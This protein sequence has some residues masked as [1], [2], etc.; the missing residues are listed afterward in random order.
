M[1]S[2]ITGICK[3][4]GGVIF[5]A[6]VWELSALTLAVWWPGALEFS[7]TNNALVCCVSDTAITYPIVSDIGGTE[8]LVPSAMPVHLIFRPGE[9]L[10]HREI[11]FVMT[12]S[13]VRSPMSGINSDG[14]ISLRPDLSEALSLWEN[15]VINSVWSDWTRA[16]LRS[17]LSYVK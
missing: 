16:L 8:Y 5:D 3:S 15:Q 17:R 10:T 9:T 4:T 13:L 12:D 11:D 7:Q 6:C 14:E 2:R 1:T